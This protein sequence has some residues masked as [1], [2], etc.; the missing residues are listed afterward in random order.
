MIGG[1]ASGQS[2]PKGPR[3][4]CPRLG[5]FGT[6]ITMLTALGILFLG[7]LG[8][9]LAA[10]FHPMGGFGA[11]DP[12]RPSMF[13]DLENSLYS[14]T[15]NEELTHQWTIEYIMDKI[16]CSPWQA[17]LILSKYR[18][19]SYPGML[20][21]IVKETGIDQ[22]DFDSYIQEKMSSTL[23]PNMALQKLLGSMNANLYL[24][25]NSP[26]GYSLGALNGLGVSDMFNG[27]VYPDMANPMA[28]SWPYNGMY[29][30]AMDYVGETDPS[31]MFHLNG[32]L[33]QARMAR[34]AGW[35]SFHLANGGPLARGFPSVP[36]IYDMRQFAPNL[37]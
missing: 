21:A 27:V 22:G 29:Y 3:H 6:G 14:S 24:M 8:S 37:F 11:M 1:V 19:K 23:S 13:F 9:C 15:V 36:S 26:L 10:A 30:D 17:E 32:N 33:P 5:G 7:S 35:N 31:K 4:K 25:S 28:G 34:S 16:N 18:S 20:H 12:T 2:V